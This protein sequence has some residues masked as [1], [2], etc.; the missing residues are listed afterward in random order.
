MK[1]LFPLLACLLLVAGCATRS[2]A[3]WDASIGHANYDE[4]VKKL[5]PPEKETTLS[6]GTRVG[7]WFQ[8]RGATVTTFQSYPNSF[9]TTGQVHEFPD[10]L[11]RFTFDKEGVLQSWKRVY[12]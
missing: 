2:G 4:I 5:G 3:N 10:A 6:D 8:H 9:L 1:K 7:D 11:L 12:R